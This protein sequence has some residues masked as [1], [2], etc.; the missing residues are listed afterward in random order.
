MSAKQDEPA[1]P[2]TPLSGGHPG[3]SLRDYFAANALAA[4]I[5]CGW[6][7][8]RLAKVEL[9]GKSVEQICATAAYLFADAMLAE[10]SKER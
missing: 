9:A 3:M 6:A 5:H 7:D 1:F 4:F 10:R 8:E 2:E